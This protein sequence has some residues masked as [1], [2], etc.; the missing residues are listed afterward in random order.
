LRNPRAG[1]EREVSDSRDLAVVRRLR[2]E[3]DMQLRV[4]LSA[5]FGLLL[6]SLLA[7][8]GSGGKT[9]DPI[10]NT[11]SLSVDGGGVT[12]E[13][14]AGEIPDEPVTVRIRNTGE[15]ALNWKASEAEAWVTEIVPN[16]GSLKPG[17]WASIDIFV[18]CA[19]QTSA[20]ALLG[21][22]DF[23]DP[24]GDGFTSIPI[25]LTVK[26]PAG[27]VKGKLQILDATGIRA[28]TSLN[29]SCVAGQNATQTEPGYAVAKNSG[30]AALSWSSGDDAEW[31]TELVPAS[32]DLAG[33]ASKG[34]EIHFSCANLAARTQPYTGRLR[35]SS[36][37]G[38]PAIEIPISV[39]VR[40]TGDFAVV[41]R[42]GNPITSVAW[43]CYAGQ[44][45]DMSLSIQKTGPSDSLAWSV[46]HA[47]DWIAAGPTPASGTLT[48]GVP[49][50][51]SLNVDCLGLTVGAH[52]GILTFTAGGAEQQFE[53][54]LSV[55]APPTGGRLRAYDGA[56]LLDAAHPLV[57]S[58]GYSGDGFDLSNATG[59]ADAV[60]TAVVEPH[61]YGWLT[62]VEPDHGVVWAGLS[63]TILVRYDC[64]LLP[65]GTHQAQI[66]FL[67]TG[68]GETL[69]V[70]VR[71]TK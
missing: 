48:D 70:P 50:G 6:A 38:D 46:A 65:A 10:D 39:S 67:N 34:I 58:C 59:A 54:D 61:T 29:V 47:V 11:Y 68:T 55:T 20:T 40:S 53:I 2:L 69:A 13:C 49:V 7:A 22:I 5:P 44:T 30:T 12:A 28:I 57:V 27:P 64:S 56:D 1:F 23:A 17:A 60:F 4:P 62:A 51:L 35:F 45:L 19:G 52:K 14:I 63:E 26:N 42:R 66:T 21:A 36:N 32:G 37:T 15:A 31:V 3:G 33:G 41:D 71:V 9:G 16:A 24:A 43:A 8:C 25:R 18:S